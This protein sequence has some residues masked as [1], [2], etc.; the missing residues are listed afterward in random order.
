VIYSKTKIKAQ[1]NIVL[2]KKNY[3]FID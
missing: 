2:Q 3:P 1:K